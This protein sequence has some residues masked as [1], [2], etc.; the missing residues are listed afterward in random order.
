M[1]SSYLNGFLKSLILE[2]LVIIIGKLLDS[3]K[4]I[5]FYIAVV[6]HKMNLSFIGRNQF[7]PYQFINR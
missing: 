7:I 2:I 5:R 4:I 1:F 3:I 6:V